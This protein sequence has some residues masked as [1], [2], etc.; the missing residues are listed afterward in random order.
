MVGREVCAVLLHHR[1]R[2]QAAIAQYVEP[3][4]AAM[5][6]E[7]TRSLDAPFEPNADPGLPEL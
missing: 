6:E 1:L 5:L 3:Q 2:I 7:L 4:I